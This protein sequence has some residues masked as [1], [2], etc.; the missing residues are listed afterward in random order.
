M[1]VFRRSEQYHGDPDKQ[2]VQVSHDS[3]LT[4]VW[5]KMTEKD[6]KHIED[7]LKEGLRWKVDT[8]RLI[9]EVRN[10]MK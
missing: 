3:F 10:Y 5:V 9:A 1:T 7:N 2:Y 6:L 8:E 4:E